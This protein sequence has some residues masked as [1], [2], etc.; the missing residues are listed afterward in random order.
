M[1]TGTLASIP[2]PPS[3]QGPAESISAQGRAIRLLFRAVGEAAARWTRLECRVPDTVPP[4][5]ALIV[6]N[7]G[8][9]GVFDLNVFTVA[10]LL[11][12]LA[13]DP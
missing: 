3:L 2:D 13:A 6:A 1:A 8:F 9:G 5:P 7:H 10:A 11:S 12:R 4:A